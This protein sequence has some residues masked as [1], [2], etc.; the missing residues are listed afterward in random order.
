MEGKKQTRLSM[1][2]L[3]GEL[4]VSG[5]QTNAVLA[6]LSMHCLQVHDMK[7]WKV[8]GSRVGSKPTRDQP[9]G[10]VARDDLASGDLSGKAHLHHEKRLPRATVRPW[11]YTRSF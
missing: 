2:V 1:M 3:L 10:R 8:V 9:P 11:F 7:T 6:K 4:K 5:I